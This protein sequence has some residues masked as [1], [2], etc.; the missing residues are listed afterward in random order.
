MSKWSNLDEKE[1]LYTSIDDFIKQKLFTKKKIIKIINKYALN[2]KILEF[3][4][5]TGVLALYLSTI[6]NIQ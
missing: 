1:I 6:N 4:V 2:K 5:G 3:C